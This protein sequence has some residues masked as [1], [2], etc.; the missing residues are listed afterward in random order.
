M[1]YEA[2]SFLEER[3]GRLTAILS[4]FAF[5]IAF[6]AGSIAAQGE[7]AKSAAEGMSDEE[8]IRTARS[9][10]PPHISDN[11]AVMA[12]GK[13]GRLRTLK[14]GTNGF[15]CLPDLSG[16]ETPDPVCADRAGTQWI[17]SFINKEDRPANTEPGIAY[18]GQG[19]WHFEK[20]GRAVMDPATPE[21][22]RMKEPP[23]WMVL[24]PIAPGVSALPDKPGR[25]GSYVMYPGTPYAHLMVHQDPMQIPTG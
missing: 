8:L 20:D 4:V 12:I 1:I 18:M 2:N 5:V 25:F 22:E 15:T 10:A 9:A 3:M 16:Q 13:D 17:I 21:A 23:H 24:W 11:A 19:G 6:S 14:E 7:N